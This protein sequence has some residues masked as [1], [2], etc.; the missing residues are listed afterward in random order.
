M[1]PRFECRRR[2]S[3]M[4]VVWDN[5]LEQVASLGGLP[6]SRQSELRARTACEVLSS[7]YG[8]GLDADSVRTH[9]RASL[10]KRKPTGLLDLRRGSPRSRQAADNDVLIRRSGK[11]WVVFVVD[12]G[13]VSERK[14]EREEWAKNYASGQAARLGVTFG[15]D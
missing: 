7:I 12:H 8:Q 4:W 14:F 13:K 2:Q 3:G 6:L 10:E 5:K 15:A 11:R 9:G 1:E